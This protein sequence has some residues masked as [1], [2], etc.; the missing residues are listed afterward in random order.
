MKMKLRPTMP[1]VPLLKA[2]RLPVLLS[3]LLGATFGADLKL[4]DGRE[5]KDYTIV[6]ETAT[7]VTIRA[8]RTVM[9]VAKTLLPPDELAKHPIDEAGAGAESQANILGR[10]IYQEQARATAEQEAQANLARKA[11][12]DKKRAAQSEIEAARAEGR[13]EAELAAARRDGGK[14]A[15]KE[16]TEAERRR[17]QSDQAIAE[18]NARASGIALPAA[19]ARVKAVVLDHADTYFK[20]EYT[21]PAVLVVEMKIRV[22]EPRAVQGWANRY[23]ATG[24]ATWSAYVS[25]GSSFTSDKSYFEATVEIDGR[26]QA[27]V[28]YFTPRSGPPLQR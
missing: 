8:G 2:L 9:K 23:E 12:N 3:C 27:R 20:T 13:R 5:F 4:K 17:R 7:T 18:I 24:L 16:L 1:T 10:A 19:A 26:G 21:R 14:E 11:E 6:A 22:D 15:A 25:Q 28:T